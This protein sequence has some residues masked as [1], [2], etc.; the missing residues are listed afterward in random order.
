MGQRFPASDEDVTSQARRSGELFAFSRE[1]EQ[2]VAQGQ[3][4]MRDRLMRVSDRPPRWIWYDPLTLNSLMLDARKHEA[5]GS[6]PL[7]ASCPNFNSM[8]CPPELKGPIECLLHSPY[9]MLIRRAVQAME[10]S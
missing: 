1:T 5:D 4:F 2:P 9:S 7:K 8:M 10:P 6:N 3:Y